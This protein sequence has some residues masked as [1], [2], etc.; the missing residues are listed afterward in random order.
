[1]TPIAPSVQ[2]FFTDHLLAQRRL[3]PNTVRAYRDTW[4]LL[5]RHV[6]EVTSTPVCQVRIEQVDHDQVLQ[7]LTWLETD[8]GNSV[9]TRNARL[10]AIRAWAAYT[11]G[12]YPEHIAQLA[13]IAAIP[14]KKHSR[15]SMTLADRHRDPGTARRGPPPHLDRPTRP[16]P[17]GPGRPHRPAHLRAR[18]TEQ[19]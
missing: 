12:R 6:A 14:V 5:L 10:A 9:T 18:R 2:A 15:P 7:F 3:S 8:R 19:P 1:M 4:R 13:R 11:A 17:A 16:C